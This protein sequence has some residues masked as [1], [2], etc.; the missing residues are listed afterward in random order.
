MNGFTRGLTAGEMN[1][2]SWI[3]G[4]LV[5]STGLMLSGLVGCTRAGADGSVATGVAEKK[6][7][8]LGIVLPE[9]SA[10]VATYTPYRR[11]NDMIYIAGQ[12]PS[13]DSE[14]NVIG[15]IGRDLSLEE[16]VNAARL[17]A[18]NILAQAKA[19]CD[20]DLD[21]IAQWVRL[22]AYVNSADDFS[23]QPKVANGASDLLV[24]V[25]GERGLHARAAVGVN[26]LPFSVA[27][28]IEASFQ[29]RT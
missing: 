2:R 8:E 5:G 17:T 21:N 13:F 3:G 18:I 11:V 28:E 19:A 27:V 7:A 12:G 6:L 24:E 4:A 15:T 25:F 29:I 22:T 20:G 26:T 10:A 1:R 16:G 14:A 23:D 9:P